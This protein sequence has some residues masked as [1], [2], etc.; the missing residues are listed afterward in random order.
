MEPV[1]H[2][3]SQVMVSASVPTSEP[4]FNVIVPAVKYQ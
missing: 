4:L 3:D 1:D 2:V